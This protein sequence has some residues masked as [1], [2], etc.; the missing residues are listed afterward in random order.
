M[1]TVKDRIEWSLTRDDDGHRTYKIKWLVEAASP[2]EGPALIANATGL[3]AI[4]STWAFASDVDAW[5]FCWPN[6]KV[7]PV[8]TKEK[9]GY[10]TVENIFT[11]KPLNRCQDSSIENPINEPDRI[12]GSFVKYTQ[13]AVQDKD[14][15]ALVNSA[16]EQ[17]RGQVVE[18]DFNRPTVQVEKNLLTLPLSTFAPMIDTVNDAAL[19]GLPARCVKLSNASWQRKLYGTCSYYYTVGYEFDINYNTFDKQ[20]LD[21][22]TM[23]LGEG[24]SAA[25]PG[26]FVKY[27]DLNGENSRV[28][29][30]GAGEPWDGA[31]AP[32]YHEFEIY[33]ESNFL[34]LGIPTSL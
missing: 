27:K 13:E 25:N 19:W 7:A 8:L 28:V 23:V 9:S 14:G 6:L 3:P 33:Q 31:S 22:G 21:E 10:W 26:D 2:N 30:D 12:S 29:L 4:G 16:H 34:T 18:V 32:Y 17:Y 24:G 15:E 5:A 20:V 11:T 1:A